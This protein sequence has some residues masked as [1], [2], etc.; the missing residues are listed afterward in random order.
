[1]TTAI[2]GE[3]QLRGIDASQTRE[4]A[5]AESHTRLMGS[6][7]D[8]EQKPFLPLKTPWVNPDSYIGLFFK[9]ETASQ[10]ADTA[11][12]VIRIDATYRRIGEKAE[13]GMTLTNK[14]FS[15]GKNIA[16]ADVV[17]TPTAN[18]WSQLG[19]YKVPAGIQVAV[20]RRGDGYWYVLV[21]HTS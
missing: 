1:M 10:T 5:L 4:V 21:K 3:I 18:R 11:D 6:V 20:G 15:Y 8:K 19:L 7:T 17:L 13:F 9:C 16:G 14:D 12:G 2:Y